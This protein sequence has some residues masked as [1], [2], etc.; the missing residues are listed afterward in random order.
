LLLAEEVIKFFASTYGRGSGY[1]RESQRR[2]DNSKVCSRCRKTKHTIDTCYRKY[3][4]SPHFNFK[5]YSHDQN[6]VN[7]NFHNA[8]SNIDKQNHKGL[9]SEGRSQQSGFTSEQYQILLTFLR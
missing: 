6:R 5:N 3:D 2:G 7:A 1:G 9:N 8:N 4:F